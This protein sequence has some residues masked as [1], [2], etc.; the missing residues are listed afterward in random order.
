MK[1][2]I[3]K[4]ILSNAVNNTDIEIIASQLGISLFEAKKIR[5]GGSA[6]VDSDRLLNFIFEYLAQPRIIIED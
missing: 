6:K 2:N 1:E 3:L 5:K 4:I